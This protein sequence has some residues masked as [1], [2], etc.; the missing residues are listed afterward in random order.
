MHILLDRNNSLS[1]YMQISDYFERLI[2]SGD[3][4]SGSRLPSSRELAASTGV[5]RITVENAYSELEAR[6]LVDRQMGSGTYVLER[7]PVATG[8]STAWKRRVSDSPFSARLR[9]DADAEAAPDQSLISLAEGGGDSRLYPVD[10]FRRSMA[11]AIREHPGAAFGYGDSRGL[12][13]LRESLAQ[14]LA[15][16]G[17]PVSPDHIL[18]TGGSQQALALTL[19]VLLSPGDAVAVDTYT[20]AR[21]LELMSF[22]RLRIVPIPMDEDGMDMDAL[23]NELLGGHIR[24]VYTMPNFQNPTGTCLSSPRRRKLVELAAQYGVTVFEDDYVGDL[25]YEGFAQP[26]LKSLDTTGNV[27]YTST[28]SKML[29][30]GLRIGFLVADEPL[31]T[32]LHKCKLS[33][34]LATSNLMQHAL[35]NYLSV[36]RYRRH[37][38]TACRMYRQRRNAMC[39]ALGRECA[40]HLQFN[41]PAGGLFMWVKL[42]TGMPARQLA[43]RARRHG[44]YLSTGDSFSADPSAGSHFLRLNFA[45]LTEPEICEAVGRLA[46]ALN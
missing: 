46:C 41:S 21:A 39:N 34:D 31:L 29:L 19:Q 33:Q 24:L 2:A 45:A 44:L 5:S 6:G 16:Q 27:L 26:S 43:E 9:L 8:L 12:F 37:L 11:Q 32:A 36:G 14:L 3:L 10:D 13:G 30:P 42:L 38:R 1:L 4:P 7:P 28:F 20:Y 15:N 18:I 25:R 23:E 40:D 22:L 35:L 17:L